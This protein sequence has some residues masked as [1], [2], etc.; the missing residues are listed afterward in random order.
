MNKEKLEMLNEYLKNTN[1]PVLV[2][3]IPLEIFSDYVIIPSDINFKELDGHYEKTEYCPPSWY[4]SLVDK[5][6]ENKAILVITNINKISKNDQEKFVEI[7]KYKK[8]STFDLA[9][10]VRI[11]LTANNL[12]ENEISEEIYSLLAHI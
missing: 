7:L 12:K 10:N 4:T 6:K 2:E 11:I 9:K 1:I 3:D 8:V 5:Y